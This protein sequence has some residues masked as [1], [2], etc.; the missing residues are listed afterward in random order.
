MRL[1]HQVDPE[2]KVRIARRNTMQRRRGLERRAE[3]LKL[4]L[5]LNRSDTNSEANDDV[6]T[7]SMDESH[8]E[9]NSVAA[10]DVSEISV[11]DENAK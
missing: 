4:R 8:S 7:T 6:S 9:S 1:I 2:I 5:D 3:H 10:D 11:E